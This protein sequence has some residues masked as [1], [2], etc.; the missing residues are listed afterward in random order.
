[1]DKQ[2]IDALVKRLTEYM[3]RYYTLDNPS[4][5]D[6]EYD[7]LYDELVSLEQKTGYVRPDS[8]TRRVGGEMLSGF[9]KQEHLSPL[10]SLDKVRTEE[11]LLAWE[12]RARKFSD[13]K[14]TY[15][16]EY[17]YDGLT[18]NLRYDNGILVSAATR[19][20]GTMGEII[21]P[22]VKTIKSVPLSIDYKGLLEVNGEALMRLSVLREYNLKAEEPLK[23]ARNAAAGALR[24]LNP[25]ETAKRSLSLFCYGINY[26]DGEMFDTHTKMLDFLRENR[27]PVS[28]DI[29]T[30]NTVP[31]I[32]KTVRDIENKRSSL[33]YLIDGIVIKVD[34]TTARERLGFTQKFPRWAVAYKFEADEKTTMLRDVI[35]QVGRTGKLTPSA[36][37]E[38]VDI[39]GVTVSKAT[40]NNA[41]DI[42]R[43]R[44]KLG[45]SVFIRRSG[46]V[47]PEVLGIAECKDNAKEI[48]VPQHCPACGSRVIEKGAHL[49]CNNALVCRPQLI[50]SVV[51]FASR[52]AMNIETFSDKTA[53]AFFECLGLTD[54]SD[55]YYLDYDKIRKLERFGEKK[56]QNLKAAVE[57]SKTRP[58]SA[59]IYALGIPGI[60]AKTAKDLANK[61][62]SVDALMSADT[63]SLMGVDGIGETLA[64]NITAFFKDDRAKRIIEHMLAAGVA[65]VFDKKQSALTP[66]SG[67]RV[68]LT[69]A[70]SRYTRKEAT[71]R[72]EAAGGE[73]VSS[74]SK[75]TDFVLA[76][77]NAG[78][79]LDKAVALGVKIISEEQFESMLEQPLPE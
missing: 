4:V 74:V 12:A 11:E 42:A 57:A 6:A 35:W 59:F 65:P 5:S 77:E 55:L 62:D 40:L 52:D 32:M 39:G 9:V 75:A 66:L 44:L 8:P 61:Y 78:G 64:D 68:V 20:D 34:S 10:Y 1:M 3:Y 51:H 24:N 43:K 13:E 16:I 41:G 33:D 53:E 28:E 45:C 27:F 38:P 29:K 56:T 58:F 14:F 17:K 21:T 30:A 22:Q 67:K 48:P 63:Q 47:I 23:N 7:K 2:K 79:K 15:I 18:V 26:K 46:D 71:E 54:V 76:G 31:E 70:L 36:V 73:V 60:G 49:F 19:G 25:A 69:G 50:R 37:L 72:I